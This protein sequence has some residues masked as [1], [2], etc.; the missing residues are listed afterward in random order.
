MES[1]ILQVTDDQFESITGFRPAEHQRLCAEALA[2]GRSVILRAPTGSGKSEAA[3]IPFLLCRGKSLPMRMIHA[4]PMRALT[5]QL[6][7]R[8][9]EYSRRTS[10]RIRVAAQHGKR[11]ESVLFYADAIFATLDQVVS[12]YACAPLS[13]SIRQGNIPAGAI[14]GSFMVF[15]EVHTF[16]PQLGLQCVLLLAE[17]AKALGVPFVLMSAT[18]PTSLVE[19]LQKRFEAELIEVNEEDIPGRR[20]RRVTVHID[21]ELAPETVLELASQDQK[22]TLVVVNTVGGAIELYD[23]VRKHWDCPIVLAHSRFYDDDRLKKEQQIEALFGRNAPPGRALLIATQVV[24]VGLDISA[25]LLLTELAP[26]DALVQRA[27]RCARWGGRGDSRVFTELRTKKPYDDKFVAAS[28]KALKGESA[29]GKVLTWQFEKNLVD[30]ADEICGRPLEKFIEPE[31]AGKVLMTLAEAAF[32]GDPTKAER[33]VREGFT[34]ETALHDQPKS[35]GWDVFRLPRVRLHPN[36]F[37]GFVKE[38]QP[39]VWQATVKRDATDDYYAE[40]CVKEWRP[41]DKLGAAAVYIIDPAFANY[42]E[43]YGLRPGLAGEPAVPDQAK[44]RTKLDA[45]SEEE[46]EPWQKHVANVVECFE[47]HVR[48][49]EGRALVNLAK[50]LAKSEQ[51]LLRVVKLV[52]IF[53]DLGKLTVAWQKKIQH[54]LK[55]ALAPGSFLAHRGGKKIRGLP[56]HATVSAWV[57]SP[58]LLRVAQP[59]CNLAVPALAAIA[60]HHSVGADST[61]SF[62][63]E[64]G[65]FGLVAGC[66]RTLA[67]V[68]VSREDFNT[69]APGSAAP[70][71]VE[72]DFLRREAYTSYILLSRWLRLA[73][74]MASGDGEDAIL[75]YEEWFGDV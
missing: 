48:P 62:Q 45:N 66:C 38:K 67:D 56:P 14:P 71:G 29:D 8:M 6:E 74:R 59:E 46:P 73:D 75:R 53:H 3:W 18:L 21:E 28:E 72:F 60:H 9:G 19:G 26:M 54:A 1:E 37:A 10:P 50:W 34:V 42:H 25:D 35:L 44:E 15:D 52:L 11:P 5:N 2:E 41:G 20:Q 64:D 40:T 55:P 47:K 27:G 33:A 4:L 43:E 63:M 22:K 57:A 12:S 17:R 36:V 70:C 61:P 30:K 13:L 24:E 49:K 68:E 58:C 23:A 16:E 32:A 39:R 31:A 7:Q 51:D 69:I 65:W